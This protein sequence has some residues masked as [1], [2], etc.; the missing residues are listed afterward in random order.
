MTNAVGRFAPS[1]SGSMHLGNVASAVLAYA[2]IRKQG[3]SFLLR[4][5]DLD[6]VRCKS[7]YADALIDD[8][9]WL[10]LD[11]D[12][13][14]LYQS[15]RDAIY[16]AQLARL[17]QSNRIY[18]CFCTRADLHVASAPHAADGQIRYAGT[19]KPLS[20]EEVAERCRGRV[21]ALRV[22][23]PDRE[24]AFCD[25]VHGVQTE[26]LEASSG[27]FVVKRADGLFAYQLA[28]VV[29]DGLSGITEVVRGSDLLSSTARQIWL[30]EQLGFTV[31]SFA[32]VP[33]LCAADGRRLSKRERDLDMQ[34]LRQKLTREVLLGMIAGLF[35]ILPD[36]APCSMQ[37]FVSAFSWE[38]IPKTNIKLPPEFLFKGSIVK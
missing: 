22:E 6:R 9:R 34:Y 11:W 12:G 38:R 16:E 3:G 7:A 35:G 33:L 28:V 27:D 24:I 5:E 21:P 20:S 13:E 19:C 23:V 15:Q 14:V 29:D 25:M 31:P 2:S 36:G 37:E 8:L 18:P 10:G 17:G 30:H 26:N 1:P 4:I 32:H